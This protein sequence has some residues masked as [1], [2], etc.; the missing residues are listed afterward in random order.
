MDVAYLGLGSN[1]GPRR[2]HL[3]AAVD[4]LSS[5][6]AI[7]VT[8][9]SPVYETEAHTA[10]PEE[11]QP[12]F[13]NAV[14]SV[15]TTCAPKGLLRRTQAIE[16]AEG[17]SQTREYWAPRPLDIDLLTV[18]TKTRTEEGLTLPH[19]RLGE[20]RFVLRPWA[21]LA[22]NFVVPPPFE[23]SVQTLLARCSDATAIEQTAHELVV[24]RAAP[25]N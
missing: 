12:S 16:R 7:H 21:D 9:A 17:R 8:E 5:S 14:L 25:G 13:L 22:P 20:R 19:P 4:R 11:T 15:E 3:Q 18:G 10:H 23:R 24:P 1:Q 2:S 6:E